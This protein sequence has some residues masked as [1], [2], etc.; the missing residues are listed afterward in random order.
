[1]ATI[2]QENDERSKLSTVLT[3][4]SQLSA[5]KLTK[6]EE[7]GTKLSFAGGVPFFDRLLKLYRDLA[8]CSL[9]GLS[10]TAL[11]QLRSQAE[12]AQAFFNQILTFDPTKG[13]AASSRDAL[14]N[15]IRDN[16]DQH[17]QIV[18]PHLA[19]AIRKGT[20]FEALERE[21]RQAVAAIRKA[22]ADQKAQADATQAQV[23]SVLEAV[24]TAAAEI[25]VSQHAI[26]FKDQSDEHLKDSKTWLWRTGGLAVLAMVAM[27]ALFIYPLH[28]ET[29]FTNSAQ[30]IYAV[31]SRLLV[32]SVIYFALLWAARNYMAHRHNYIVN[33]H[34]QNALST[35]ETF[36]KAGGSDQDVKNAILL[37]AAQSIFTAQPSGY[38]SKQPVQPP[39]SNLVEII[40]AA[41]SPAR[42]D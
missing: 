34:R 6:E 28:P 5:D 7:L 11:S 36:V 21:A 42:D 29:S 8:A 3:Q 13:N 17:F 22:A 27:Y 37:Q 33:K 12:Q 24:R 30:T 9:D 15:Q 23:A 35:F 16:Y 1:M 2:E 31:A 19:Y 26:N 10:H 40:K 41:T 32:F 38:L 14:I 20:D 4:L 18:E 39:P 25:G